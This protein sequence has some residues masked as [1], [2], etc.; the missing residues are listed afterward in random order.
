MS[1]LVCMN[2]Y[3]AHVKKV[4]LTLGYAVVFATYPWLFNQLQLASQLF[5]ADESADVWKLSIIPQC[6]SRWHWYIGDCV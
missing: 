3:Q 6:M 4:P 1:E 2:G 5:G